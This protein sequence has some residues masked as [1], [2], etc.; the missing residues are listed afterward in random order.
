MTNPE[1]FD[2]D[3]LL[4]SFREELDAFIF[5]HLGADARVAVTGGLKGI[6]ISVE[7]QR[8]HDFSVRIGPQQLQ[9][10]SEDA[11]YFET[12]LLDCLSKHRRHA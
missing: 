8:V 7:H 6:E 1:P 5:F 9:R 2:P 11:G 3:L 4:E 10:M 12:I